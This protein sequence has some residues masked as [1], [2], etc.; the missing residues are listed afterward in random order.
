MRIKKE[1]LDYRGEFRIA[2]IR[3]DAIDAPGLL[4]S[5]KHI[6]APDGKLDIYSA[7]LLMETLFGGR[8][9]AQGRPVYL[10]RG[11]HPAEM[12]AA[13][14]L[15]SAIKQAGLKLVCDSIDQPHYD[16]AR[17]QDIMSFCR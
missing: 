3:L 13:D 14:K 4:E 16:S 1:W 8:D 11:W 9:H 7:S 2:T 15:C 6:D 12:P 17:I 5:F 10:S